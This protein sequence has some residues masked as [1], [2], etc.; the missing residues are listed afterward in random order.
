MKENVKSKESV[1][2]LPEPDLSFKEA[3][4]R[5]D[6]MGRKPEVEVSRIIGILV[7]IPLIILVTQTFQ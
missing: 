3:L 4:D 2:Q 1:Y 7:I 5:L 6:T